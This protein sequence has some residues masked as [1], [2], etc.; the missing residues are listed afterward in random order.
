MSHSAAKRRIQKH[1]RAM[2]AQCKYH[3]KIVKR[4][5]ARVGGRTGQ[6][7]SKQ[8]PSK[9]RADYSTVKPNPDH[10][11]A[12]SYNIGHIGAPFK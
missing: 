2:R 5:H 1:R 10:E 3:P 11:S 4:R 6:I 8:T 12:S 9:K 7:K